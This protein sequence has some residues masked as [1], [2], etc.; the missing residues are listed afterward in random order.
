[1]PHIRLGS[2]AASIALLAIPLP[3]LAAQAPADP[4]QDCF[5]VAAPMAE[6]IPCYEPGRHHAH[7]ARK[8]RN[9]ARKDDKAPRSH[10]RHAGGDRMLHALPPS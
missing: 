5:D 6:A 10:V 8:D 2:I 3:A 1:M 4:A 7:H 9:M